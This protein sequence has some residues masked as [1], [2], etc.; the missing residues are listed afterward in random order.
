VFD[1]VRRGRLDY[2]LAPI[3]NSIMGGVV[4]TQDALRETRGDPAV[5]A[6]ALVA[7]R[8][9]LLAN[10]PPERITRIYSKPEVFRQ[11][12][13]FLSSAYPRAEQVAFPSSSAA[14]RA[15]REE[16]DASQDACCAAIG[17]ALAA[18][19]YG[20]RTLFEGVEDN[21]NNVTRFYVL[22]KQA[23]RASGDDKTSI[24][25]TTLDKPG[26]LVEALSVFD[27]AGINLTHIDKR[28]S[29]RENWRYTFLIDAQGHREDAR[30]QDALREAAGHC[31]ELIVLG[32]YP[33]ATRVL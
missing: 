1:E 33:R 2:G 28:P 25:F 31:Q 4:E 17:S 9:C 27:R 21:P 14:V 20:L 13:K 29:G 22:A 8:H 16:S 5:Y 32:S 23:A 3:E 15:A 10:A 30:M 12:R 7:V 6:E 26:A 19:L 11:C 24:M 18:Q